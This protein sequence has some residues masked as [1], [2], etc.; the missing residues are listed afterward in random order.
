M[1]RQDD[2]GANPLTFLRSFCWFNDE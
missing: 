1:I 2:I